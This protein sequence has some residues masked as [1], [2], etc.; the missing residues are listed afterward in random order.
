MEQNQGAIRGQ[1]DLHRERKTIMPIEGR[2]ERRDERGL[3]INMWTGEHQSTINLDFI[4]TLGYLF[5]T[6][7]AVN[8]FVYS[9]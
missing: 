2:E 8:F 6:L 1:C 5:Y 7:V 3:D 4:P 9:F